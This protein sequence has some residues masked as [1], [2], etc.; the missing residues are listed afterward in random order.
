MNAVTT[1][2]CFWGRELNRA[3]FDFVFVLFFFFL[4]DSGTKNK[5]LA[6]LFLCSCGGTVE[7]ISGFAPDPRAKMHHKTQIKAA[8]TVHKLALS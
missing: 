7:L 6:F 1:P 8:E 4:S 5:N 2:K 3:I